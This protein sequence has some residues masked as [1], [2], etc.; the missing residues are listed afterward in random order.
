MSKLFN[1]FTKTR[2]RVLLLLAIV[3]VILELLMKFLNT[4]MI[5]DKIG[6]L[7]AVFFLAL[8]YLLYIRVPITSNKQLSGKIITFILSVAT[9]LLFLIADF[10]L[11]FFGY[12]FQG[13]LW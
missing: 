11:A 13:E 10:I 6:N 1:F 8:I 3:F 9:L 12:T 4:C 7:V 2:F 5:C